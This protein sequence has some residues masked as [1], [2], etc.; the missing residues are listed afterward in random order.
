MVDSI[1]GQTILTR[2]L[3]KVAPLAFSE[4]IIKATIKATPPEPHIYTCPAPAPPKA[5]LHILLKYHIHFGGRKRKD[6]ALHFID[7]MLKV[8]L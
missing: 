6:Y 7:E 4:I 8:Y 2:P 1:Q 3:K 5:L